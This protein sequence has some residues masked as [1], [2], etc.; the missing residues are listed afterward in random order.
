MNLSITGLEKESGQRMKESGQE[1]K[2]W[3]L[4]WVW[5]GEDK[6]TDPGDQ[7]SLSWAPLTTCILSL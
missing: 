3:G 6:L 4:V 7:R 1:L 5:G 2:S